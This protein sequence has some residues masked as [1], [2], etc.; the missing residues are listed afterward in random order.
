MH[1]TVTHTNG[2]AFDVTLDNHTFPIDAKAEHGGQD[3]G[4]NPKSLLLA[5][6][7]GCTGMDVVSILHKMRQHPEHLSVELDADL[8]DEHPRILRDIRVMFDVRGEVD[9]KKLWRAVALSRDQY[10]GV[11][12]MLAKAADIEV[13]IT[14]NGEPLAEPTAG[15]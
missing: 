15:P 5:A 9:P 3:S 7:G 12:A 13:S 1:S 6:L 4:P 11:H 10:C 2:M 14:L 8:T